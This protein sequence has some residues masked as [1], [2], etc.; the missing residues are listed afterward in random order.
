MISFNLH[1]AKL[2]RKT[3]I[4]TE[5]TYK[6]VELFFSPCGRKVV[7]KG[8]LSLG[9]AYGTYPATREM[10]FLSHKEDDGFGEKILL[11][12]VKS[13]NKHLVDELRN[14]GL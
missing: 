3:Y 2:G 7:V 6:P 9:A 5:G 1:D 14:M 13:S 11:D 10:P 12:S 4:E 8:Y